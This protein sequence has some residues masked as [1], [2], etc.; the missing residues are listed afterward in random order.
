MEEDI[1]TVTN[2]CEDNEKLFCQLFSGFQTE[3]S[4]TFVGS[5]KQPE[6]NTD[7]LGD[8]MIDINHKLTFTFLFPRLQRKGNRG[9]QPS[10]RAVGRD[11]AGQE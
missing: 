3:V 6:A 8:S 9:P 5:P 4:S 2:C 10:Q 11:L 1:T 7:I